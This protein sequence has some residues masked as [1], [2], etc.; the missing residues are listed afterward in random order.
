MPSAQEASGQ[1]SAIQSALDAGLNSIAQRQQVQFQKYSRLA[2]ASDGSVFWIA[3][4]AVVMTAIGSLHYAT[5]REQSETSTLGLSD[6]IFSS[7]SE[8]TQFSAIAPDF[9][10]IGRW[11]IPNAPPLRVAFSHLGN[12][13][14]EAEIYHYTGTA[15]TA[16]MLPNIIDNPA[17]I[18]AGPIV[19]NS[20]PIW[21]AQ[22]SYNGNSVQVFPSFLVP[23]NLRPPYIAVHIE[24]SMTDAL[25]AFPVIGPWPGVIEPNSGASPFH[26]LAASQLCRDEVTLTLYG[27]SNDAAWQYWT[28]LIE[29]SA[30]GIAPFGFA[31]SPVIQDEKQK[32]TE[33]AALAQKKT[34]HISANY[35]QGTADAVARRLILEAMLSEITVIGGVTPTGTGAS[36]QPPPMVSSMGNVFD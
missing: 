8:I 11:D 34:L 14:R 1:Q 33:L 13:F 23:E 7:E 3:Q 36:I 16:L 25:G 26:D 28:A 15:I 22:N 21:L 27:F 30:A 35:L 19:S 10:W 5:D 6:V 32:Q 17:D 9:M 20:L 18:P 31:N 24:P 12:L 4:Q 2:L 29:A